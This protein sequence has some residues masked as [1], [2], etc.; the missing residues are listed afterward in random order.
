MCVFVYNY[1]MESYSNDILFFSNITLIYNKK[2]TKF[3]IKN[4]ISI[5]Q[6]N[7]MFVNESFHTSSIYLLRGWA[8]KEY[9]H[10]YCNY[11]VW[12]KLVIMKTLYFSMIHYDSFWYKLN[13]TKYEMRNYEYGKPSCRRK[14]LPTNN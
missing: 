12:F 10:F 1:I 7:R 3:D 2:Q 6:R 14:Y 13:H 9:K 4:I 11:I 5:I 8:D